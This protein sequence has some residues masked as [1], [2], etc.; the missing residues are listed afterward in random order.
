MENVDRR[1]K[2][3]VSSLKIAL[4]T[5]LKEKE[6]EKVSIVELTSLAQINRKTFYLHYKKVI[7]VYEDIKMTLKN[8]IKREITSTRFIKNNFSIIIYNVF[9]AIIYDECIYLLLKESKYEYQILE[10]IENVLINEI[11]KVSSY[12][13]MKIKHHVYGC[14]SVFKDYIKNY[15]KKKKSAQTDR[16]L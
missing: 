11:K 8:N 3:T 9:K 6:I 12:D 14:A 2:K 4:T 10:L 13:E 1:T 7:D 5:L 16:C 15:G